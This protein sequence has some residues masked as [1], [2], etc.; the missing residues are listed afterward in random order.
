L[1]KKIGKGE[2]MKK[3]KQREIWVERKFA[4]KI[5]KGSAKKPKGA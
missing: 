1:P 4:R 3:K 2:T 5:S